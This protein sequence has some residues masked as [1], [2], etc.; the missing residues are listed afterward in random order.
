L[1]LHHHHPRLWLLHVHL[2]LRQ[3]TRPVLE[4]LPGRRCCPGGGEPLHQRP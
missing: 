1:L 3:H 4:A 2:L